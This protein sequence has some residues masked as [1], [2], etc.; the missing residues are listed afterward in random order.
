MDII[1]EDLIKRVH[2]NRSDDPYPPQ[3]S[4]NNNKKHE[5]RD[6]ADDIELNALK[7]DKKVDHAEPPI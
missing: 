5:E 3:P 6:K 1:K 7:N 4:Q 2:H